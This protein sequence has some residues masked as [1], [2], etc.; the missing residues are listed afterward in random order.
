L[1]KICVVFENGFGKFELILV[2]YN[3]SESDRK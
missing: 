2:G 3:G 1:I